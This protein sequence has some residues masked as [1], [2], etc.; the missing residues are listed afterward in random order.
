MPVAR[1]S[2]SE[3]ARSVSS[4]S[5]STRS[6]TTAA[7]G[8]LLERR[9][10][11]DAVARRVSTETA[12]SVTAQVPL[13]PALAEEP[14]RDGRARRAVASSSNGPRPAATAAASWPDRAPL[15]RVLRRAER[16]RRSR[17]RSRA[18]RSRS[19]ATRASL[20]AARRLGDRSDGA[21][22]VR[23]R[24]RPGSRRGSPSAWSTSS[25]VVTSGGMIRMTFTY[26][27]AVRTIRLRS[28][29]SA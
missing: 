23:R 1:P 21:S 18:A 16:P 24:R 6:S 19:A 2:S 17:A 11:R 28:S 20:A 29:A 26:V 7:I 10:G 25:A 13:K 15:D 8:R 14:H 12:I 27:P 22:P 3:V 5:A 9:R 4:V